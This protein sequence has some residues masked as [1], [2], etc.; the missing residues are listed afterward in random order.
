MQEFPLQPANTTLSFAFQQ[1]SYS[2]T[3]TYSDTFLFR[4]DS[5]ATPHKTTSMNITTL[6]ELI[7]NGVGIF[8]VVLI[9]ARISGLRTFATMSS[10]DFTSTIA[11]GSVVAST[12]LNDQISL[13]HGAIAL[14]TLILLQ[15]GL[16]RLLKSNESFDKMVTNQP[17]LLMR[18]GEILHKN[19][20][21]CGVSE[22]DLMAKL[23]EANALRL[24]QVKAVVFETT[25]D[26]AVLHSNDGSDIDEKLLLGVQRLTNNER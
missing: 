5:V 4:S 15:V 7:L 17:V 24:S 23:R 16:G 6:L 18:H 2:T 21:R 22:K 1:C 26:I 3:T 12:I 9:I 19:L 13:L 8:V 11:V 10:V 14:A 25:G 20:D